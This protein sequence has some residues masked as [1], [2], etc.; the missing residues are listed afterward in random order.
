MGAG[1]FGAAIMVGLLAYT[2]SLTAKT[3]L[4]EIYGAVLWLITAVLAT[5]A[6]ICGSIYF[7]AR[8]IVQAIEKGPA[9]PGE[10]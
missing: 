6:C 10:S 8:R 2:L 5:G 9:P 3:S 4:H 1:L 7:A